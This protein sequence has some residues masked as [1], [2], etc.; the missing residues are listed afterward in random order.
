[1]NVLCGV[2]SELGKDSLWGLE[3]LPGSLGANIDATVGVARPAV[4]PGVPEVIWIGIGC[5]LKAV[6]ALA[7]EPVLGLQS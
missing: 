1:M 7:V 4:L 6:V 2:S 3:V 5:L